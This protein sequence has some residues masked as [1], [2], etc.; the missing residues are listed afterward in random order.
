VAIAMLFCSVAMTVRVGP[1]AAASMRTV[2]PCQAAA[3]L[4]SVARI[5][6]IAK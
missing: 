3:I 4:V 5:R 2:I 1:P 6:L